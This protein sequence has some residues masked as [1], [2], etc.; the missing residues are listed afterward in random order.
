MFPLLVLIGRLFAGGQ[1]NLVLAPQSP[2]KQQCLLGSLCGFRLRINPRTSTLLDLLFCVEL[3]GQRS[4]SGFHTLALSTHPRW[5]RICVC[6]CLRPLSGRFCPLQLGPTDASL[7][8]HTRTLFVFTPGAA[9][10]PQ[11]WV[12]LAGGCS[13]TDRLS[14]RIRGSGADASEGQ[15][16]RAV[17]RGARRPG[18]GLG[19]ARLQYVLTAC[20]CARALSMP[21]NGTDGWGG[22]VVA[23]TH[24]DV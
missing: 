2:L 22:V 9:D 8:L 3:N 15:K 23:C 11:H 5:D 19:G 13:V 12:A 16:G 18:H 21:P 4:L 24:V 14:N 1:K 7:S 6:C 17:G 20:F 10:A